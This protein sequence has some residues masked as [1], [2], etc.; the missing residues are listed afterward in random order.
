LSV[1]ILLGALLFAGGIVGSLITLSRAIDGIAAEAFF[2]SPLL[3]VISDSLGL[4]ILSLG[5]T[6]L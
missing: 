4:M 2:I 1:K 5:L 6:S 3:S